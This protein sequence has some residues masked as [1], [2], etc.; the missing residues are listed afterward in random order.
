MTAGSEV[1]SRNYNRFYADSNLSFPS[2]DRE[3]CEF[4]AHFCALQG[5]KW[6]AIAMDST[7][8]TSGGSY[9]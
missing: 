3:P 8:L 2:L 4:H 9:E 1:H 5:S 6:H 7:G